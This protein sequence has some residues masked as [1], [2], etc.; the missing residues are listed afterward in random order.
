MDL[1]PL[2]VPPG[3][4]L[5]QVLEAC[6]A[7][8]GQTGAFVVCG[9]GSLT[10]ARLRCAGR[11]EETVIAGP[12]ELISLAGS[13]SPDG[14]HLHMSVSDEHGQVFGGHVGRGNTVRTTA[15][16]LLAFLPAWHLSREHD[17]GTGFQELVVRPRNGTG[18]GELP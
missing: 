5:R 18:R 8:Q 13:L 6:L 10:G 16:V 2:R 7:G 11:A 4:D 12:L 1:F 15:E 14:A 17:A 3:A 9:I